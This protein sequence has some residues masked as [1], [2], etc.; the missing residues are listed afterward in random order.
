MM[1]PL[2]LAALAVLAAS[3]ARAQ[4]NHATPTDD[5]A[6][7]TVAE[8]FV[9]DGLRIDPASPPPGSGVGRAGLRY[10][11][12]GYVAVV[13]GK[14]YVR[15]RVLWGG[16]VAWDAV[17]SAGAHR[18]TELLTTV[19]LTMGG[20]RIEPG[21]VSL[22]VT[23]RDGAPWTL[24]VNRTL[25]AHLADEYEQ[26]DDHATVDA[27]PERLAESVDGLTWAFADDGTA[28]TLAWGDTSVSFPFARAD[29]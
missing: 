22:L 19:P 6:P 9:V 25:G 16:L 2:L 21:A 26:A 18:A 5:G 27:T 24:H 15:G 1:R 3:G 14:P 4:H 12:G 11:D 17:W 23:P 13:Y 10:A 8:T 20:T 7:A 28:V 29:S